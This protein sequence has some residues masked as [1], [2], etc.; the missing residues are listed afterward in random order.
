MPGGH[1]E[2]AARGDGAGAEYLEPGRVKPSRHGEALAGAGDRRNAALTHTHPH[3]PLPA[4]HL[5]P[6]GRV[7][8]SPQPAG[9]RWHRLPQPRIAPQLAAAGA[10][11]GGSVTRPPLGWEV[12]KTKS[13]G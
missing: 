4:P 6:E 7:S 12:S 1:S 3:H 9:T 8:P 5:A 2:P 11:G 10:G 13:P